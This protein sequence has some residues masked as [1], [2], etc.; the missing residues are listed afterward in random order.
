LI[1]QFNYTSIQENLPTN[2][3]GPYPLAL[4]GSMLTGYLSHPAAMPIIRGNHGFSKIK[5]N[6]FWGYTLVFIT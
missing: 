1:S 2:L 3:F 4:F 5:S 6:I